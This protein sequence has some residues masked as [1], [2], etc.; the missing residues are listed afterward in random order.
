[1]GTQSDE[2][3]ISP[4]PRVFQADQPITSPQE[5][6]YGRALLAQSLAQH[7]LAYSSQESIVIGLTGTW[8]SGK[9]SLINLCLHYIDEKTK[10]HSNKKP[11]VLRFTPWYYSGSEQLLEQ[12]FVE[13]CQSLEQTNSGPLLRKLNFYLKTFNKFIDK[14]KVKYTRKSY[15]LSRLANLSYAVLFARLDSLFN[16][17]LTNFSQSLKNPL[18]PPPLETQ[19]EQI[20]AEMRK[21]EKKVLVVIDDIDRLEPHEML[22]IF[23]LVKLLADF[24][25]VIYLL[26]FDRTVVE[27]VLKKERIQPDKYLEKIVQ[28]PVEVTPPLP[29]ALQHHILE[30]IESLLRE[31]GYSEKSLDEGRWRTVWPILSR[32]FQTQRE[33]TRFLNL[34]RFRFPTVK[35]EVDAVDFIAITAL[36]VFAPALLSSLREHKHFLLNRIELIHEVGYPD[37]LKESVRALLEKLKAKVPPVL[38]PHIEDLLFTLFPTLEALLRNN[39]S[40]SNFENSKRV[41]DIFAFDI[42]LRFAFPEFIVT[43]EEFSRIVRIAHHRAEFEKEMEYLFSGKKMLNFVER[44]AFWTDIVPNDNVFPITFYLV[45]N[46]RRIAD[47]AREDT[48]KPLSEKEVSFFHTRERITNAIITLLQKL[49]QRQRDDWLT[50]VLKAT[51]GGRPPHLFYLMYLYRFVSLRHPS[52]FT[53]SNLEHFKQELLKCAKP[54]NRD[55]LTSDPAL[56]FN[57]ENWVLIGGQQEAASFV[58]SIIGTDEEFVDFIWKLWHARIRGTKIFNLNIMQQLLNFDEASERIERILKSDTTLSEEHKQALTDTIQALR[59]A[60]EPHQLQSTRDEST[61]P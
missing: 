26:A 1:M 34:L 35:E 18:N 3:H 6:R 20:S 59:G 56:V 10:L 41:C 24:P 11:I 13:L 8:G 45:Q 23:R 40:E 46:A 58:T 29:D 37:S 44:L 49:N 61:Q 57:L 25:N 30:Q 22:Q 2:K 7:I 50:A 54:S 5:D 19:K 32:L 31:C 42:Y 48:T 53:H 39:A 4:S 51:D 55:A 21:L 15:V 9:T 12:F 17:V 14:L 38:L 16:G 28:I 47:S 33:A 36:E 43:R 27:Q 60:N 52:L